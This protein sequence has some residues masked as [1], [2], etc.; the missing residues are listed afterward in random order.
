MNNGGYYNKNLDY[1]KAKRGLP[2]AYLGSQVWFTKVTVDS[3]WRRA[4][5]K[6]GKAYY[7]V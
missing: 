4:R 5:G 2:L 3:D 1:R 7:I 6:L